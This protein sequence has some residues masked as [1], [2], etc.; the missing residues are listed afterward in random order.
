MRARVLTAMPRALP[1]LGA[2]LGRLDPRRLVAKSRRRRLLREEVLPLH[3]LLAAIHAEYV[4][5]YEALVAELEA[6]PKAVAIRV[7]DVVHDARRTLKTYQLSPAEGHPGIAATWTTASARLE[8]L[9]L[10]L[11]SSSKAFKTARDRLAA[12][13]RDPDPRAARRV[14]GYF[15]ALTMYHTLRSRGQL[16]FRLYPERAGGA[17]LALRPGV[18]L[19][20]LLAAP[21]RPA[22]QVLGFLVY[23]RTDESV[24]R[25]LREL[26]EGALWTKRSTWRAVETSYAEL[27]ADLA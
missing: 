3:G 6:H 23:E 8:V 12:L 7:I 5:A 25:D 13:G 14:A 21:R 4:Q 1:A 9:G 27:V 11:A 26:V 24:V 2:L 19:A 15:Q 17:K 10:A 20:A 22:A 16:T 18:D